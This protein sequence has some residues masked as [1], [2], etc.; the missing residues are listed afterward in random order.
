[1]EERKKKP[2][3]KE[4]QQ[5]I[6]RKSLYE[7]AL[8]NIRKKAVVQPTVDSDQILKL[9]DQVDKKDHEIM[10]LKL[11]YNKLNQKYRTASEDA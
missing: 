4:A 5:R 8:E 9:T 1:M 3:Y 2:E 11:E 10:A 6:D 7:E